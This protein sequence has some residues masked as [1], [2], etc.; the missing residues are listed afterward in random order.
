MIWSEEV[1]A[2]VHKFYQDTKT[3]RGELILAGYTVEARLVDFSDQQI[4]RV[5]D[6]GSKKKGW[7]VHLLVGDGFWVT[8]YR[9]GGKVRR[10]KTAGQ[11][12]DYLSEELRDG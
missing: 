3:W 6:E 12:M 4:L 8:N 2:K 1:I 5:N 11:V 9:M 10:F 7:Y